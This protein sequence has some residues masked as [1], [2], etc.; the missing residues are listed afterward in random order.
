V[1]VKAADGAN[2]YINGEK[3]KDR[4]YDAM[5]T[6]KT[7][8]VIVQEGEKEP[9]I[10]NIALKTPDEASVANVIALI[11]GLKRTGDL[12]LDDTS[13]VDTA[14]KAYDALSDELK[15]QVPE[16]EVQKLTDAENKMTK[17]END[18][19][20]ADTVTARINGLPATDSLTLDY[21]VPVEDIRSAYDAL[22]A[23]QKGWITPETLKVLTDAEAKM[24]ALEKADAEANQKAADAVS[25][26]IAQLPKG[27]QLTLA[28]TE[29]VT[30][31]REDYEALTPAQKALV[32]NLD[33]LKA[34][35]EQLKKLGVPVITSF[36]SSK[37]S[38][39]TN[40]AT[41]TLKAIAAQG[42]APYTYQFSATIGETTVV[43]KDY[44][45][46]D[47]VD[48]TP[49]TAG[50]YVLTVRVMDADGSIASESIKLTVSALNVTYQSH[51]ENFGWMGFVSNGA[52]AGTT[53]QALRMEALQ[54]RTNV[55]G[56]NVE[57]RA[58][59]QNIGWQNW[60]TSGVSSTAGT[61]GKALR[62]EAFEAKLEGT[63]A[64]QYDLYYRTHVSDIGW[65]SWVKNGD[66]SGTTGQ[67]RRMEAIQIVIVPKGTTPQI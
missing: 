16:A 50:D 8:R 67:A 65:L 20:A 56:V 18:K 30:K 58:H 19:A 1:K 40:G 45:D 62:M 35:E 4:H 24:A 55:P 21:K 2:V 61:T 46:K 53:G 44:D 22:T 29:K 28:D 59:C 64:D 47:T 43:L 42:H 26:A 27:D 36:T 13:A 33:A 3:T 23:D 11:D 41:T 57:Y 5:N 54:V 15:A 12:T 48:F 31:A 49:K 14:K 7:I 60:Q 34:A 66:L 6:H 32:T 10:V 25:A 52:V 38:T 37:G 9:Y 17:L 63:N 51:V 39:M